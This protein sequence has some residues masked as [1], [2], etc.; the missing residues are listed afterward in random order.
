[1]RLLWRLFKV[2]FWALIAIGIG[3]S[4]PIVWIEAMCRP[5]RSAVVTTYQPILPSQSRRP[6]SNTLLTW[7]E[8]QIV[9]AYED[10]AK[11]IS[12][13]DP[14]DYAFLPE[15]G[16][17]WSSLCT[18]SQAS[19]PHGGVPFDTKTMLYTIGVSFTLELGFKALYEETFGRV[20]ALLRGPERAELDN[21]SARMSTDYAVFL[22]QLPWYR[23]DFD[24]DATTLGENS[25]PG[26]RNWERRIALGTEFRGK[27][28]YAQLIAAAVA[29]TGQ[30]ELT[31]RSIVTGLSAADLEK[32][33]DVSVIQSRPE[34]IEIETP[35]YH[36]FT[37]L[38]VMLAAKGTR[39]V[40]I[41]GNDDVLYTSLSPNQAEPGSMMDWPRQGFGDFRHLHLV[42]VSDLS[43]A[44][45]AKTVEH[46]HDY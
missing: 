25:T 29:A 6:E 10:Y 33:P 31:M 46:I 8:W 39:F 3:L 27:A 24:A 11:V 42:K 37:K 28:A 17:F 18:V 13:G 7:P 21:L 44:L 19:G 43:A 40:E 16:R 36:E 4:L 30:D 32:I 41:A 45:L 9:H 23:W 38:A 35:R 15:V 2:S 34:G 5:D 22:Y 20:A 14:H 1:M 12:T 26:F